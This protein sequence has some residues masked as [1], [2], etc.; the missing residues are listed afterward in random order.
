MFLRRKLLSLQNSI[1][2]STPCISH[3]LW[4]HTTTVAPYRRKA[5]LWSE[6]RS[7]SPSWQEAQQPAPGMAWGEDSW[8]FSWSRR[9][10]ATWMQPE[11]LNSQNPL[12]VTNF[13][14][15]VILSKALEMA[16]TGDQAFKCQRLW[17]TSFFFPFKPKYPN[18]WSECTVCMLRKTE[19]VRPWHRSR[20][21]WER[22]SQGSSETPGSGSGELRD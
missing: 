4:R 13:S 9:Q 12:L 6:G 8:Q 19:S 14:S 15:K 21:E 1:C 22:L 11:S 7:P 2:L 5:L 17:G 18:V 16:P 10:R 20:D 3:M